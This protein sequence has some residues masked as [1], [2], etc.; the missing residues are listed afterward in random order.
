LIELKLERPP[1]ETRL[2]LSTTDRRVLTSRQAEIEK[3]ESIIWIS[4][5]SSA[6]A[7]SKGGFR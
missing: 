2:L 7:R 3:D 6:D 4:S 5:G 1:T